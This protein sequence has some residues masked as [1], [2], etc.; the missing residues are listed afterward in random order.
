MA[1]FS[2]S[3]VGRHPAMAPIATM[4]TSRMYSTNVAPRSRDGAA[5]VSLHS[6]GFGLHWLTE[7]RTR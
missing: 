5:A 2:R 7:H 4:P 1:A 6:D 3:R